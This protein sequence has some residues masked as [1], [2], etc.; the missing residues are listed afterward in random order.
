MLLYDYYVMSAPIISS[1]SNSGK[2]KMNIKWADVDGA[3]GYELQ[4]SKMGNF[5]SGITKK[6]IGATVTSASY[7]KLTKGKTYYV[8]IRS[9]VDVNGTKKYSGWSKKSVVIKK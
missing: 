9:Y 6:S 2:K 5:K 4:Y 8:R 1:I 7:S 3:D